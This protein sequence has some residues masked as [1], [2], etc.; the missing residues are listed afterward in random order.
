MYKR[1]PQNGG[2]EQGKYHGEAGAGTNLQDQVD[3][4]QRNDREGHCAGGSK[5]AGEVADT[6]PD[7]GDVGFE[8]VGVDDRGD[9]VCCCLLYTSRCV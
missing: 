4:E 1:Q 7:Y 9:G 8:R 2:N 3:G 6:R 5:N